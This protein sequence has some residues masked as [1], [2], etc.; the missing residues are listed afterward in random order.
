MTNWVPALLGSS[1]IIAVICLL[2]LR[3]SRTSTKTQPPR[4]GHQELLASLDNLINFLSHHQESHW[5]RL[6]QSVQTDL[7]EPATA[8]HALCRLSGMFGGMGSLNDLALGSPAADQECGR[9]L[10][11]LFR[12]MKLYHGSAADLA[13]WQ[14]LENEYKDDPPPRIKHAFSKE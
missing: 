10:D 4:D 14:R 7:Q 9:L 12:N 11:L 5:A 2:R 13:E 8:T 6:L 1:A 3:T